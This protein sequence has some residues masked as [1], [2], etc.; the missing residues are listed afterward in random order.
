VK[1]NGRQHYLWR[2]VDQDGDVIDI[3]LQPRRDQRAADLW[4]A[5]SKLAQKLSAP[6][7][8]EFR[9]RPGF[10]GFFSLIRS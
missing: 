5:N 3:L 7:C 1:I 6:T 8:G 4:V 9:K 2:A 10:C